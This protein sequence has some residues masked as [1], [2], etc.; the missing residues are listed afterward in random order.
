[1]HKNSVKYRVTSAEKI[2][3]RPIG[4]D[5]QALELAL[6]ACHLLGQAVLSRD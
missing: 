2:L 4:D 3:G 1:M 6:T 5:R